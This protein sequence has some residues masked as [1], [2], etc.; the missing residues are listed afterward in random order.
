[1]TPNEL[2]AMAPVGVTRSTKMLAAFHYTHIPEAGVTPRLCEND[3]R[4]EIRVL[5]HRA[6]GPIRRR[7]MWRLATV[8]M[9]GK[10]VMVIQNGGRK[11]FYT[12]RF[13]TDVSLFELMVAH[14]TRPYETPTDTTAA[15]EHVP[16]VDEFAGFTLAQVRAE[17]AVKKPVGSMPKVT[18][19]NTA[20]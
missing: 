14:L 9:D 19:T 7:K 2:Y 17:R 10:P 4:V 1:M 5:G 18:P 3:E 13:I 20:P 11:G 16:G 8:W 15:D 12:R 6:V